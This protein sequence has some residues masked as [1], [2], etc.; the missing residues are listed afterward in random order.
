MIH[1]F[2]AVLNPPQT[3]AQHI[4]VIVEPVPFRVGDAENLRYE[5]LAYQG[6]WRHRGERV[7]E[8]KQYRFWN[9]KN[10]HHDPV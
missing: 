5:G 4:V 6:R 2:H 7:K 9:W 8:V 3:A 1:G 10:G